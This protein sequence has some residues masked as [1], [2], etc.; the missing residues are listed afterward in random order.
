MLGYKELFEM[1]LKKCKFFLVEKQGTKHFLLSYLSQPVA[2]LEYNNLR[3]LKLRYMHVPKLVQRADNDIVT[4][5]IEGATLYEDL[6]KGATFKFGM[7]ATSF[8]KMMRDFSD[9]FAGKRVGNIDLR[10]YI[11]K[12][13]LLYSFDFDCVINGTP[14]E[15]IA[16]CILSV[17]GESGIAKERQIAFCKL[18]AK[19]SGESADDLKAALGE[20]LPLCPQ[21]KWKLDDLASA[22]L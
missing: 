8:A 14:C 4:E 6:A 3:I 16:D 5:Y 12:G 13:S 1:R 18:L 11:V 10:A 17:F 2:D 20:L 21:V 19:A 9:N 7:I 22:I 15:A